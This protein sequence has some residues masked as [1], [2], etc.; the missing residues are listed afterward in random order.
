MEGNTKK[1]NTSSKSSKNISG[2]EAARF[3]TLD[4]LTPGQRG[5]IVS[6]ATSQPMRR[7]LLDIG[8]SEG[9][10]ITCIMKS[11]L[12]DPTAYLVR[13]T[14]IALRR[15][16]AGT[17]NILNEQISSFGQRDKS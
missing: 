17:V 2:D 8:F 1:M 6:L 9:T 14:L 12:G 5:K 11:P 4:K 13:G 3:S 10:E 16:E 7:R 15:E